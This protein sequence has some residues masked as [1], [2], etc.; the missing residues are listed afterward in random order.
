VNLS[1]SG[2]VANRLVEFFKALQNFEGQLGLSIGELAWSAESWDLVFQ[3]IGA[4]RLNS[5]IWDRNPLKSFENFLKAQRNLIE[6]PLSD[7]VVRTDFQMNLEELHELFPNVKRLVWRSEKPETR[8][9][10]SLIQ[11]MEG[12]LKVIEAAG[13]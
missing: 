3:G 13:I 4:V 10:E 5:L 8:L 2:L 1:A 6:L 7:C 11:V 12:T 9:S